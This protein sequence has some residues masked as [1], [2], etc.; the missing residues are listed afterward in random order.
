MTEETLALIEGEQLQDLG[1]NVN[2]QLRST[3][4]Q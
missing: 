1:R 4:D 3:M 2:G